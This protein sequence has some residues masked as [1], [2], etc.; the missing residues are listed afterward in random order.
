ML[1]ASASVIFFLGP[2]Y[3]MKAAITRMHLLQCRCTAGRCFSGAFA[4]VLCDPNSCALQCISTSTGAAVCLWSG[5][6][7]VPF[8]WLVIF[9][10]DLIERPV[11]MLFAVDATYLFVTMVSRTCS[12]A[13][14]RTF[15][16]ER[17]S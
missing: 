10:R 8:P 16:A 6:F 14:F 1:G 12:W 4:S 7:Y 11:A 2:V 13:G 5:G 9:T 3:K 15:T 17:R